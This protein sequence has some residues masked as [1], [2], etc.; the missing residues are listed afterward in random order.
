MGFIF[1][2]PFASLMVGLFVVFGLVVSTILTF[3][4]GI[5]AP[6]ALETRRSLWPLGPIVKYGLF[7]TFVFENGIRALAALVTRRSVRLVN[8][9]DHF[10]NRLL[11]RL[12]RIF[13]FGL[14]V[15]T[16]APFGTG[17][18]AP[19]KSIITLYR[20]ALWIKTRV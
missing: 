6:P 5:R 7:Y 8:R 1:T 2:R 10:V 11:W 20:W 16:I 18:R 3:G 14:V 13:K 15:S 9:W 4:T 17:I 12:W 19:P